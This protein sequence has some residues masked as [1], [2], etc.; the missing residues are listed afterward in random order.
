[1]QYFLSTLA[2]LNSVVSSSEES[3]CATK[4]NGHAFCNLAQF[5]FIMIV[6]PGKKL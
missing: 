1:M 3:F 4:I 6:A 2:A 5:K